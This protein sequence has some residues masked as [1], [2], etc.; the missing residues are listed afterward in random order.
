MQKRASIIRALIYNPDVVLMDEPF[1]PLDAQTRMILQHELLTLWQENRMTI[2][3]I[4]HDLTE[5]IALSDRVV[6]LSRGPG[7]IKEVFPIGLARPRNVF[8]IHEQEGFKD[9]YHA[10]WSHFRPDVLLAG[11]R[12]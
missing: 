1:G 8:E 4:T 11:E 9:I 6:L 5:S 3:F 10:I 2:L 12:T 7:R